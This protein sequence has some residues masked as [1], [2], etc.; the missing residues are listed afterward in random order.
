MHFAIF[1]YIYNLTRPEFGF[2]MISRSDN[3]GLAQ[4]SMLEPYGV[5]VIRK[6]WMNEKKF[7]CI[8]DSNWQVSLAN[9]RLS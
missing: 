3:V 5:P 6:S 9:P 1:W 4:K 2:K 7:F 8:G